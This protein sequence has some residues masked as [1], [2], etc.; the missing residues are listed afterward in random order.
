MDALRVHPSWANLKPERLHNF[1]EL[2]NQVLPL[3]NAHVVEKLF[4]TQ[5]AKSR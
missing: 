3:A 2:A 5:P 4:F 1:F